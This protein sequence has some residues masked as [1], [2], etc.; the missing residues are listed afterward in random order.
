[1]TYTPQI[2]TEDAVIICADVT[3]EGSFPVYIKSGSS[4]GPKGKIL[5]TCGPIEFGSDCIVEENVIIEYEFLFPYIS[6]H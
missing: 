1:M 2:H 4:F 5:A 3:I 6:M